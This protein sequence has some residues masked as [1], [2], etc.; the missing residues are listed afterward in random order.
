MISLKFQ[1]LLLDKKC[2]YDFHASNSSV[3]VWQFY[4]GK[5]AKVGQH[6]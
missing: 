1:D 3:Q 5:K 2:K 4:L 6:I